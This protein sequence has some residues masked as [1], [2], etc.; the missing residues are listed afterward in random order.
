M[1]G[2]RHSARTLAVLVGGVKSVGRRLA[3]YDRRARSADCADFGGD[4]E[5]SG[6]TGRPA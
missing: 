1:H 2:D 3:R 5:V 6:I 4:D